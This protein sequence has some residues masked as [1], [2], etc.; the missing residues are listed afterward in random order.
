MPLPATQGQASPESQLAELSDYL[1]V[2]SCVR[3]FSFLCQR[4]FGVSMTP[5]P[6]QPGAVHDQQ[7]SLVLY[8]LLTWST[9]SKRGLVLIT[10]EEVEQALSITE[11]NVCVSK[12]ELQRIYHMDPVFRMQCLPTCTGEGWADGVVKYALEDG[13]SGILGHIYLDLL[14]RRVLRLLSARFLCMLG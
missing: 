8:G 5:V 9:I 12:A 3:G 2:E 10:A 7:L 6:L 14:P 4:L 1:R 13:D 11:S